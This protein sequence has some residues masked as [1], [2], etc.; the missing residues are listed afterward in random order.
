[1]E[2]ST[3][4]PLRFSIITLPEYASRDALPMPFFVAR[5]EGEPNELSVGDLLD[6]PDRVVSRHPLLRRHQGEHRLLPVHR[7]SHHRL[8]RLV[9][10]GV[11]DRGC[12]VNLKCAR[13][14]HFS[15]AC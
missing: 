5:D 10:G 14:A 2:M 11:P 4:R 8:L 13:T 6:A 9:C 1:M 7:A 12:L 3:L 15:A